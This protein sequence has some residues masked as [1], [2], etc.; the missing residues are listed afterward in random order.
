MNSSNQP[1][2][3][4][5][6]AT[7]RAARI[8]VVDD[9]PGVRLGCVLALKS[10][11]WKVEGEGSAP[12]AFARLQT[13][14]PDLIVLDY[15]MPGL[16]GLTLMRGVA[17]PR[18]G[19]LLMSAHADGAVIAEALQLGIVD[20]LEKPL[21]PAELRAR[22]R[23]LL[24]RREQMSKEDDSGTPPSTDGE[25][26][27]HALG[28]GQRADWDGVRHY[29]QSLPAGQNTPALA[30]LKGLACDMLGDTDGAAEAFTLARFP[31]DWRKG[32]PEIMARLA[33][34]L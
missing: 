8:L 22:V 14:S 29:L 6:T 16:D 27:R 11:E 33:R 18:P 7:A 17:A 9:E 23:R 13:E 34:S 5:K 32:G 10:E 15:M 31:A 21:V 2:G 1:G 4:M 19:V 24:E 3:E 20:F 26:R 12:A 25:R 28:L 30:L